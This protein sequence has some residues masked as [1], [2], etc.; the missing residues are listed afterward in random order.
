[1]AA[2]RSPLDIFLAAVPGGGRKVGGQFLLRC[3]VHLDRRPSLAVRELADDS[4]LVYCHAGCQTEDV[5][6][7]LG[8]EWS[9]L[10]PGRA[11]AWR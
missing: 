10:F 1:V 7:A 11:S 5:L 3:P 4:L 2:T 9:D 6:D 8:L